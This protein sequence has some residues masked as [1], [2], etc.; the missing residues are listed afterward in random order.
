M[1][2]EV[3]GTLADPATENDVQQIEGQTY[4]QPAL[5]RRGVF[6]AVVRDGSEGSDWTDA[7]TGLDLADFDEIV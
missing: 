4:F 7:S 1:E 5:S 3:E 2:A 6:P